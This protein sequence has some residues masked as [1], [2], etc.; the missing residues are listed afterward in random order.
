MDQP[1]RPVS[2]SKMH[3]HRTCD[4]QYKSSGFK[5]TLPCQAKLSRL[6]RNLHVPHINKRN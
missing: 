6:G 1:D 5:I 3:T 2:Q 4:N